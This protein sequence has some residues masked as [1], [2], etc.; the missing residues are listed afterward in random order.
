MVS[1]MRRFVRP[2]DNQNEACRVECVL[3]SSMLQCEMLKAK[4]L[5]TAEHTG[6]HL[7]QHHTTLLQSSLRAPHGAE[8]HWHVAAA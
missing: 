8:H 7:A 2:R 6:R 1:E 3:L 4:L 5:A